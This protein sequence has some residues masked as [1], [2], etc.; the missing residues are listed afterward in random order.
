MVIGVCK[1]ILTIDEV[2]SLKEKR[3]IVKSLIERIKSRFNASVAEV[4]LND[5]WKRAVIGISCV[6]NESRHADSMMA[7]IVN[8]IENDGRAVL[9]DYSTEIIHVD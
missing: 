5:K 2:Y 6:S 4:D 7:N 3:H 8:F 1:V 9:F